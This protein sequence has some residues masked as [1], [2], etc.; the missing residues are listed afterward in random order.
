MFEGNISQKE[1]DKQI[2]EDPYDQELINKRREYL[3]L[4][5]ECI[6]NAENEKEA[7]KSLVEEGI[8]IELDSLSELIDKYQDAL[9]SQKDLY[10]Y[11]KRVEEQTKN[12]ASLQKQLA[13]YEGDDSEESKKRIQELK[14]SLE[15]AESDLQE[16]EYDKYISD[17][18]ALLDNL[19]TEYELMLNERI[20]NLDYLIA[21]QIEA[22]NANASVISE[23]LSAE[24]DA[25]GYTLSSAMTD[26]WNGEQAVL[27]MYGEDFKLSATNINTTL[28][29]IKTSI[30]NMVVALNKKAEEK[31]EQP[32]TKPSSV[33]DP[34]K[35]A[36]NNNNT[37]DNNNKKE[38]PKRVITNDT[39]MG[40]AAAIWNYQK[41]NYGGWGAN[42]DRKKKLTDKLGAENAAKVQSYINSY[43]A[44]G[45]LYNFWISKGK[46]LN[47]YKYSAF[48]L[49]A[50]NIDETQLA[51]TQ[52]QGQEYIIRPSDGAILTPVAKGDSV[53]TSA[54][55]NNI[56]QMANS[57][58][59]FIRDN[60]SLG[61]TSIPN[62]STV[63]NSITQNFD[64]VVFS[65]PNV[66]NYDELITQMQKDPNFERL[67]ETMSIGKL[68]GKS[69][70]AKGKAIR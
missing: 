49:G 6:L 54:A 34:V 5:R 42:P 7:I 32:E 10:D 37:N 20:D 22:V 63:Q 12:I 67:V 13:A 52:E 57:P 27:T 21:Q 39:L 58:T 41:E 30:D 15:E 14:V 26:I 19:Y 70:L 16:T 65:M 48:K 11:Q 25:V 4:Q 59:E 23:T 31:I 56:W 1:L 28:N 38:E 61:A 9:Q 24:A 40:I 68:T 43:G 53:L 3:E 46:N 69:S 8:E 29:G 35:I 62:N 55:T 50:K 51:W 17:T 60:L 33:E 47:D 36:N 44:T 64:K 2:A 66:R 45:K 18:S